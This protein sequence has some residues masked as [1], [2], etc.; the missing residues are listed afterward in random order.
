MALHHDDYYVE[1]MNDAPRER[2]LAKLSKRPGPIVQMGFGL[3]AGKA[4]QGAIGSER[5]IDA[6]YVSQA[7]EMAEFLESSTKKYGVNMLMSDVFHRLLH[8]SNRYRCRIVDQIVKQDDDADEDEIYQGDIIELYTYDVNIDALWEVPVAATDGPGTDT[9]SDTES[10]NDRLGSRRDV[11]KNNLSLR[12]N[13]DSGRIGGKRKTGRRMSLRSLSG[14]TQADTRAPNEDVNV[15]DTSGAF[16]LGTSA[17]SNANI[18][19]DGKVSEIV[20]KKPE[21]VLP[22]GPA[23]YNANIWRSEQM[24]KIRAKYSDGLFFHKFN[25]G[26][27]SF[28]TQDW[29]HARQCFQGILE[30]CLDDGPS[31]YFLEQ[32]KKHNGKPPPNFRGYGIA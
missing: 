20:F 13:K 6:T 23:L 26:L 19:V 1:T 12:G 17:V 22:T 18:G 30:D 14:K 7:V 3:H 24:L 10:F 5:K 2:L 32:I 21:L 25:S 29:D 27:Q 4:V 16:Q 15:G 28:Y 9:I 11:I 8:S 31:K